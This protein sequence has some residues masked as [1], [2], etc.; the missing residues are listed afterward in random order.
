MLGEGFG[1]W[2]CR[3]GSSWD[4]YL[5][6]EADTGQVVGGRGVGFG[7]ILHIRYSWAFQVQI[8]KGQGAVL[9]G[10]GE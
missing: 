6:L 7:R 10:H 3:R 9:L 2:G 1:K 8:L 4:Q 5:S